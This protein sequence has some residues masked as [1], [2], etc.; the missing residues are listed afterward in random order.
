MP[1]VILIWAAVVALRYHYV[2][3]IV[4]GAALALAALALAERWVRRSLTGAER[5]GT[6]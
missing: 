1:L 6:S 3:D 4:A 5:T 2:V